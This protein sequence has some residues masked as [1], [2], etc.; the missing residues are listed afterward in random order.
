MDTQAI[1]LDYVKQE[2]MKGRAVELSTGDDLL[3]TGIIDSIGILQLVSFIEKRF[4]VKVPD[5]DVVFENFQSI[6]AMTE[7]LVKYQA[8]N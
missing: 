4:G 8:Q 7:Y 6:D 3:G 2:L 1:L 5:E